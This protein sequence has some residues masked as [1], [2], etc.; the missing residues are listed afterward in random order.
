MNLSGFLPKPPAAS[1]GYL[2]LEDHEVVDFDTRRLG[3]D[4]FHRRTAVPGMAGNDPDGETVDYF[5]TW[6]L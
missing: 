2:E 4:Y 6:R 3:R 5:V 1:T